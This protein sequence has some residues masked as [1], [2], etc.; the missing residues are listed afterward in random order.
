MFISKCSLFILLVKI[1]TWQVCDKKWREQFKIPL[2][3]KEVEE[4]EGGEGSIS[5]ENEV[6]CENFRHESFF[7]VLFHYMIKNSLTDFQNLRYN[8]IDCVL[9]NFPLNFFLSFMIGQMVL[10]RYG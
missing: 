2:R 1:N 4:M 5:P 10:T 6:S 8:Y 3:K 9:S 7:Y